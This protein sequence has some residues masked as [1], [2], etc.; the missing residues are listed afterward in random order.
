MSRLFP[1]LC[2][3]LVVAVGCAYT[4]G[5]REPEGVRKIAVPT[6]NNN[7]FRLRR[8]LE[9]DLTDA[10]RREIQ[11]RTSMQLVSRAEADMLI[12][13]TIT[14]FRESVVSEGRQDQTLESSIVITVD[15]VIENYANQTT[16]RDRIVDWE[17]FSVASGESIDSARLRAIANIAEEVLFRIERW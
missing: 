10:V 4:L 8:E 9:F 2:C 7:T 1:H 11:G 3:V 14:D 16:W 15:L 12:V 17:P 5:P 13:G 6:F